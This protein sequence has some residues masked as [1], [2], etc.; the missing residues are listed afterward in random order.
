MNRKIFQPQQRGFSL[1]EIMVGLAI[2]LVAV[3]IMMQAFF[4]S[5]TSRRVTGGA[6]DAQISG[7]IALANLERDI[8]IAGYGVN[9]FKL[10]G[11]TLQFTPSKESAALT[12]PLIIAPI[13]IN[14]DTK[15]VPAGDASTDTL[16]V[17]YGNGNSPTEG[18]GVVSGSGTSLR[19]AAPTSFTTGDKVLS[20]PMPAGS[21]SPCAMTV[22]SVTN[23]IDPN[24][25][26][27]TGGSSKAGDIMYNLGAAPIIRA[28]AVRNG[29][30]TVCD[31]TAYDCGNASYVSTLDSSVWV[32]VGSNLIS[33]RAEYGRDNTNGTMTGKVSVSDYTQ[34]TPGSASDP[35]SALTISCNWARV[36][37][38]RL[39]IV[40]RSALRD[41]IE[42]TESK[43]AWASTST[44]IDLSSN[45]DW[46][47][48]RY[49]VL[50]TAVP[51]RNMIWQGGQPGYQGG[52]SGC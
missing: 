32:P 29:N 10:I 4:F 22:D 45:S 48:Y 25:S 38:V 14:P 13:V 20:F 34:I 46:K 17:M 36:L 30:L 3:I 21:V 7:S 5:N 16:L 6:D 26:L 41:N 47:H 39:A 50:Q 33:L 35:N 9:S 1:I 31:Y 51:M 52:D 42:I 27:A 24:I 18:D 49:K 44:E 2:G 11:C 8:R 23:V 43:L 15:Y 19:M 40:A 37:S 12:N 28:Y